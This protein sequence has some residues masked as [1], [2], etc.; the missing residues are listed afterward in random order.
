MIHVDGNHSLIFFFSFDFFFDIF[1]I[2]NG[3]PH[4]R[5]P[6]DDKAGH[7]HEGELL[8]RIEGRKS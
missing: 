2:W 7:A 8:V 3:G 4:D 6:I 5:S 1:L